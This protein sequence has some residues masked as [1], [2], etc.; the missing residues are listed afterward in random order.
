VKPAEFASKALAALMRP[1]R[2]A[3]L[4]VLARRQ[5]RGTRGA[6]DPLF[7]I[8]DNVYVHDSPQA[9]AARRT[10]EA[11][12][13]STPLPSPA[14]GARTALLFAFRG[15]WPT[16]VAHHYLVAAALAQL[17]FDPRFVVCGG[18]VE[19]CGLTQSWLPYEAPP[20]SCSACR[21]AL[22]GLT[23]A[24]PHTV[25]LN[26]FRT[27]AEDAQSRNCASILP[28]NFDALIA[29]ALL[30]HFQ[31]DADAR[32]RTAETR[33]YA[34]AAARYLARTRALITTVSPTVAVLFNGMFF[35][36]CVIADECRRQGIALIHLERGVLPNSLFLSGNEPAC[37]YRSEALWRN[38]AHGIP[39]ELERN[40]VAFVE[41]R[42][43]R[44]I[45]PL[46]N[47]RGF[48][49]GFSDRYRDLSQA[50]FTLFFAPVVHDTAAMGKEGPFGDALASLGALCDA[51][52]RTQSTLV[53]RAHPDERKLPNPARYSICDFLRDTGRVQSPFIRL[54]DS[55]ETWNPYRLA[56]SARLVSTYNGTI[57]ME[58]PT[59]GIPIVNLGASH[60]VGKGF[61]LEPKTTYDLENLLRNGPP[62]LDKAAQEIAARYLAF[63]LYR[64]TLLTDRWMIELPEG[65]SEPV[66]PSAEADAQLASI[67]DRVRFLLGE[68]GAR[69]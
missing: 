69:A 55:T 48:D 36:E 54:L 42:R 17:G 66:P 16:H 27:S 59:L 37:H 33:T 7:R 43:T 52:I 24:L 57:G 13:S 5:W 63:Y 26:A 61:T 25:H 3:A 29:P 67:T 38:C 14:Q 30:R 20:V 21:D 22:H 2:L 47:D 32:L 12:V 35:P 34:Q 9:D 19:R 4:G 11:I 1:R 62:P 64:A 49:S 45:D 50:P 46:G 6:D 31:G 60:Y 44:N 65:M 51:A 40:A 28:N 68:Q 53:V 18:G 8:I 10:I 58:C 39:R 56:E 41:S 23:S 15:Q